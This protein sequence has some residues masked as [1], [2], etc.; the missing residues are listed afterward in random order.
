MT[1]RRT[2]EIIVETEELLIVNKRSRA[3]S[4]E[5]PVC[6][7]LVQPLAL[8]ATAPSPSDNALELRSSDRAFLPDEEGTAAGESPRI[9]ADSPPAGVNKGL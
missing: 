9:P 2:I 4:L 8:A 7:A 5:C 6:G 3:I 1:K